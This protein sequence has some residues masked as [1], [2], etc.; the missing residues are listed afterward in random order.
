MKFRSDNFTVS[1]Q[2]DFNTAGRFNEYEHTVRPIHQKQNSKTKTLHPRMNQHD[3]E[4][5]RTF[6]MQRD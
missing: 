5:F 4:K 3:K 1:S 6:Y 2:R